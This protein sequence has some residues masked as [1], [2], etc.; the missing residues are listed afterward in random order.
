MAIQFD[1]IQLEAIAAVKKWFTTGLSEKRYFTLAGRAGTGKST[2]I[3]EAITGLMLGPDDV[4]FVAPTGKAAEVMKS[5]GISGARTL[6]KLIYILK[7]EIDK[8]KEKIHI[9]GIEDIIQRMK[10]GE[11]VT[12]E[13]HSKINKARVSVTA[14]RPDL[15]FILKPELPGNYKL[16][17]VDEASM[18]DDRQIEDLESFGVPVLYIGDHRQL[19]PVKGFNSRISEPDITLEVIHRQGGDSGILTLANRI[20]DSMNGYVPRQW[21]NTQDTIIMS[22]GSFMDRFVRYGIEWPD[23]LLCCKNAIRQALNAY[24]RKKMGFTKPI[25]E[26]GDKLICL[27]NNYDMDLYNGLQ[28]IV[29]EVDDK[30]EDESILGIKFRRL[31]GESSYV[32]IDKSI[33]VPGLP[34]APKGTDLFDFGY[35]VT[36]HKSQGSEWRNVSYI[37]GFF[38]QETRSLNYTAVTRA[39]EKLVVVRPPSSEEVQRLLSLI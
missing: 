30:L 18:V 2:I 14:D 12:S 6:H 3:R 29:E 15:E 34:P 36:V 31:N 24:V 25:P 27:R 20:L 37:S 10:N 11:N 13:L 38:G 7:D 17:V 16:I 21:T 33:F 8:E 5:K 26:V 35:A 4:A 32:M 39:S 9:D 1:P 23:Q 28:G 22:F 19:K